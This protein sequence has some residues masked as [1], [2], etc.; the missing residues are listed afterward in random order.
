[1]QVAR[2]FFLTREKTV[3]R[4]LREVLLAWKIEANLSK[5]EIL[6]LY[7][8]QIFLG[9]RAYGFAAAS[10][11][12]FGKPLK[13]V[14]A[15]RGGDARRPAQGAVGLQPG[16]QPQAR[17]DAPAVRA[18]PDA[19]AAVHHRRPVRGSTNRATCRPAGA[20]RGRA[21]A[22]RV[23]RR[24]GAAGGVRRLR[25]GRLHQGPDRL[26]DDPQGRPGGRL[27]RGAAGRAR[28]RPAAR[29][30]RAGGLR[31][32][33][34]RRRRSARRRWSARSRRPSDSD[35]L[36]AGGGARGDARPRS[37][38]CWPTARRSRSPA[39]AS[40]SSRARSATRRARDADPPR[41]P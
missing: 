10:Q 2:N 13:D 39:T 17:Q 33:A 8:N 19:R 5:D 34:G 29:L 3:T 38:R 4:K 1:M 14:T 40:S 32:P 30:P 11:I 9:Q 28:L 6:E 18:A 31:Q 22:R 27:C 16:H 12:Y 41:A 35:E 20:A 7:V 15:G 21:D 36:L 37:R 25:R 26:H 24:D 23:R